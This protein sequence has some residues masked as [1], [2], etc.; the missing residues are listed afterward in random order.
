[1]RFSIYRAPYLVAQFSYKSQIKKIV[2]KYDR[3]KQIEQA[4]ATTYQAPGGNDYQ[5]RQYSYVI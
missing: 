5:Q 1:M 4:D 2:A 3:E